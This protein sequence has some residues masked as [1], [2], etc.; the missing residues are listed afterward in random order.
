MSFPVSSLY[1]T[2][3][4][5]LDL[6]RT[7]RSSVDVTVLDDQNGS[8]YVVCV[9]VS[10]PASEAVMTLADQLQDHALGGPGIAVGP[11]LPVPFTGGIR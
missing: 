5:F 10:W 4:E 1:D 7:T 9:P 11:S 2:G 3:N 8:E 6:L